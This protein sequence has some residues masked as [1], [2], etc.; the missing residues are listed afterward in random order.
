M[1]VVLTKKCPT[2]NDKAYN[3]ITLDE[4]KCAFCISFDKKMKAFNTC[5]HEWQEKKQNTRITRKLKRK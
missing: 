1:M 3:E 2:C 5:A 4:T